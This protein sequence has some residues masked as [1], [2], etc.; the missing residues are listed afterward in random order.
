VSSELLTLAGADSI[1]IDDLEPNKSKASTP[2]ARLRDLFLAVSEDPRGSMSKYH[3]KGRKKVVER[4]TNWHGLGI[5]VAIVSFMGGL[6]L[7]WMLGCL[8]FDVH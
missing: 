5:L 6:L 8:H 3:Y 1:Q 2:T 4:F 7:L